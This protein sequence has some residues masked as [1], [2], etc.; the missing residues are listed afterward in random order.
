MILVVDFAIGGL[1]AMEIGTV[2]GRQTRLVVS[3]VFSRR[4]PLARNLVRLADHFAATALRDVLVGRDART[5]VN[6]IFRGRE[7]GDVG[8][9]SLG[10]LAAA[11]TGLAARQSRKKSDK[12]DSHCG[13]ANLLTCRSVPL[14]RRLSPS[15]TCPRSACDFNFGVCAYSRNTTAEASPLRPANPNSVIKVAE[16]RSW[17]TGP[18]EYRPGLV[19]RR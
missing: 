15:R 10:L 3:R 13:P 4:I 9:F 14:Q 11:G 5:G 17:E 12:A 16:M 7:F 8:D 1:A 18:L 19:K 2:P 6:A